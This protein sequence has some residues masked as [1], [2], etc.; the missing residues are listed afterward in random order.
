MLAGKRPHL[1]PLD[2]GADRLDSIAAA[3]AAERTRSPAAMAGYTDLGAGGGLECAISKCRSAMSIAGR[4][5]R[6]ALE[7]RLSAS[8]RPMRRRSQPQAAGRRCR[9]APR[10]VGQGGGH[11]V[12]T[13]VQNHHDAWASMA[14]CCWNSARRGSAKLRAGVRR[15]VAG[16]PRRG[17]VRS[18]KK[19]APARGDHHQRR[20]RPRLP[21]SPA[22]TWWSTSADSPTWSER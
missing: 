7:H 16:P 2:A 10:D 20:L 18:A 9:G 6:S 8:S 5:R 1:S 13:A 22:R 3:T 21:R 19:I 4:D 12:T 17:V 14:T 15:L 11:E